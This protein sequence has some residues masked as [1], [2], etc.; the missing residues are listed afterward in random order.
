MPGQ[1]LSY[2]NFGWYGRQSNYDLAH[3]DHNASTQTR[4]GDIGSLSF[5]KAKNKAMR[6]DSL[7]RI[8]GR[9]RKNGNNHFAGNPN[10]RIYSSIT[11]KCN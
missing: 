7:F 3:G 10:F 9:S 4:L 8:L 1:C 5:I 6:N 11:L 2:G